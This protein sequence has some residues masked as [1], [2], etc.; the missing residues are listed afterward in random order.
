[1]MIEE[2][3]KTRFPYNLVNVRVQANNSYQLK[4][5]LSAIEN[6][7]GFTLMSKSDVQRNR[8]AGPRLRQFLTFKDDKSEKR[9][10]QKRRKSYTDNKRI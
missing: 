2:N 5:V 4:R 7:K 6:E 1:M 8:L 3:S 9:V 10:W